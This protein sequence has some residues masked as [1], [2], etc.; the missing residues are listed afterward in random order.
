MN[1]FFMLDKGTYISVFEVLPRT[2]DLP[3]SL[4]LYTYNCSNITT[5]CLIMLL[6]VLQLVWHIVTSNGKLLYRCKSD[7]M[8]S[9]GPFV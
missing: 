1:S 3:D 5:L 6:M 9:D 8:C 4:S 2:W 7:P